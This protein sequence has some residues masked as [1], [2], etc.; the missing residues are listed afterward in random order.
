[1]SSSRDRKDSFAAL[2]LAAGYSSR[3]GTLKPV[4][5]LWGAPV[6]S[7]VSYPV[8]PALVT[9]TPPAPL[10]DAATHTVGLVMTD[11][12]GNTTTTAEVNGKPVIVG[13]NAYIKPS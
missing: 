6:I 5:P 7:H 13:V 8:L 12:S 10:T 9:Y 3:M 2:V 4:L 11:A 1:M